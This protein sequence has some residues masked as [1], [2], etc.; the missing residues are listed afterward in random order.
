MDKSIILPSF[1]LVYFQKKHNT[2]RFKRNAFFPEYWFKSQNTDIL[3]AFQ[4]YIYFLS[5]SNLYVE[6]YSFG[7]W[8]TSCFQRDMKF[9]SL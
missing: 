7:R 8:C 9:I 5:F 4:K 6:T 3:I 1:H 2:I